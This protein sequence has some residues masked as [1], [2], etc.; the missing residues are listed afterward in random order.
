MKKNKLA[1]MRNKNVAD[2]EKELSEIRFEIT[3]SHLEAKLGKVKNIRALFHKRRDIAQLETIIMEK[4][5]LLAN[6]PVDSGR[7][8]RSNQK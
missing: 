4:E 2:L 7:A 8:V 6:L 5:A 1:E 3:K